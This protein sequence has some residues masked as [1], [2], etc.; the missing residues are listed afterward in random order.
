M[1]SVDDEIWLKHTSHAHLVAHFMERDISDVKEF[2]EDASLVRLDSCYIVEFH[3][4]RI[5]HKNGP[6]DIDDTTI[7]NNP[8]I[9]IPIQDFVEHDKK[10]HK[11]VC[12]KEP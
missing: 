7:S 9:T 1:D 5:L 2:I 11:E 12:F 6:T 10:H 4:C 8:Y 3:K